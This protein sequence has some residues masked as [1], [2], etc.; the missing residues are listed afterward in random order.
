M[1]TFCAQ[2][3]HRVRCKSPVRTRC[4][5]KRSG[6]KELTFAFTSEVVEILGWQ[7]GDRLDLSC[8]D[9][10]LV[11]APSPMGRALTATSYLPYSF[12]ASKATQVRKFLGFDPELRHYWDEYDVQGDALRLP[13]AHMNVREG[14]LVSRPLKKPVNYDPDKI[15]AIMRERRPTRTL[16]AIADELNELGFTTKLGRPWGTANVHK[17]CRMIPGVTLIPGVRRL[18]CSRNIAV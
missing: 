14:K 11:I 13:L 1:T 18:S 15:M 4:K 10:I 8:D 16:Q 6:R 17:C 3:G 9:A 5:V 2:F 12:P 7:P